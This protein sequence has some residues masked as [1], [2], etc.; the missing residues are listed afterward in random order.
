MN[1]LLQPIINLFAG[2][3]IVKIEFFKQDCSERCNNCDVWI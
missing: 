2:M 1:I 3:L